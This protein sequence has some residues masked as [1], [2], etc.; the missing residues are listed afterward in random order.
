[1][2]TDIPDRTDRPTLGPPDPTD[3]PGL[4]PLGHVLRREAGRWWWL[5]LLA[6]VAWFVI[7]WMVL[8]ADVTSLATVGVLIGIAFVLA[9]VN[10][11]T[12][13]AFMTGGWKVAHYLLALVFLLG[14]MWAFV[15]PVNTFFALASV[16]GLILF[17]QGALYIVLGIALRDVSPYW[18]LELA[19]GVLI[20]ALAIWVSVSDQVWDL[21]ARAAFIL[22]WVGLMAVFR[23]G[24][25][26][27]LAFSMLW[28]AKRGEPGT[29]QRRPADAST[30]ASLPHIPGQERRS[31]AE[32]PRTE[33]SSGSR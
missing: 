27:V 26:M 21:R 24:A 33:T 25:D 28:F 14:A 19:I 5:P 1:M 22:L 4:G 32:A 12:Q 29:P 15:R 30:D 18:G 16:L 17:L 11:A 8:R 23:G 3:R 2:R 10:E 7:A 20:T 9:A 6:G 13:G 31:A